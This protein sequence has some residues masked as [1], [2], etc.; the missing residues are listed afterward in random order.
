MSFTRHCWLEYSGELSH[1]A[2]HVRA[3]YKLISLSQLLVF[4]IVAI[5]VKTK[6]KNVGTELLDLTSAGR[7]LHTREPQKW[8]AFALW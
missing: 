3:N 8:T 5:G 4:T 2:L 7:L 6:V 1:C